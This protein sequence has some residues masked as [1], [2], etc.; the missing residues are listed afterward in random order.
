MFSPRIYLSELSRSLV[1]VIGVLPLASALPGFAQ[2]LVPPAQNFVLRV[3]YLGSASNADVSA[4][5]SF[6][7]ET[8]ISLERQ[9]GGI[10]MGKNP[11][12]AISLD[13]N[14]KLTFV[15]KSAVSAPLSIQYLTALPLHTWTHVAAVLDATT[16]RLYVN[17]ALVA[18]RAFAGPPAGQD[19]RFGL[20]GTADSATVGYNSP[21]LAM[22]QA[23]LWSKALSVTEL[24]TSATRT[25][26]GNE[27]DLVA[28][29][30]LDEGTGLTARDIGPNHFTASLTSFLY[31]AR[32]SIFDAGPY[33]DYQAIASDR[34]CCAKEAA[35]V[36]MG[37][38]KKTI[39]LAYE[40]GYLTPG[41]ARA[42]QLTANGFADVTASVL[43]ISDIKVNTPSDAAVAD[44]NGDGRPDL[45]MATLGVDRFPSPGGQ[46]HIFIQSADGKLVDETA[47]RLPIQ[48]AFTHSMAAA[49]ID[50]DGDNDLFMGNMCCSPS[51]AGS[52]LGPQLYINDGTGRFT[53]KTTGLPSFVANH[54]QSFM[55]S[56]FVDVNNDRIPDLVLGG[57]GGPTPSPNLILLNDGRGNFTSASANSLPPRFGADRW[58][59][60]FI[61]T[62][63]FDGDG[64]VDLIMATHDRGVGPVGL[65]LL[66]NNRNGTFRDASSQIPFN[67]TELS[68]SAA[69][70]VKWIQ[71]LTPLDINGDGKTDFVTHGDAEFVPRLFL[72]QGGANFVDMTE[73]LPPLPQVTKLYP[74]DYDEDGKLDL[75]A[76]SV[77]SPD[78]FLYARGIKTIALPSSAG[79]SYALSAGVRA[80][81]AQGE[82]WSV[83]LTTGSDCPWFVSGLPSW[84][85]ATSASSGLGSASIR[86]QAEQNP[87]SAL[88][89]NFT[90]AGVPFTIF[91]NGTPT[92]TTA[93]CS[94]LIQSNSTI[95]VPVTGTS[96]GLIQVV[97]NQGCAW[98]AAKDASWITLRGG[99]SSSGNGTVSFNVSSNDTGATRSAAIIIAGQ[100]IVVTQAGGVPAGTPVISQGGLVNTASYAPGG[101]PNGSLAQGS[102]FSIY[103]SDLG[104]DQF[105]KAPSYPLPTTLGGVSVAIT[106]A[107]S[108]YDA[109]LVFTSK[110]QINAILPSVV[111][112]GDA[113]VVITFN[114]KTSSPSAIRV[115][116][117]SVGV[118]FQRVG[119]KDLAIAQNIASATEYP[120]NLPS[121]PAKPGQIVIL[122]VTGVGPVSV[123]DNVA[124]GG[125]D[126]T[127]VPVAI[128]VGGITAQRLYAG[129]QPETAAVDNLYF[130]VPTNAPLGCQ[131]PV[132]VT[133]G[134]A[135][136]NTTY[137]AISANGSSCQ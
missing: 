41:P 34:P 52:Q 137:I 122:W 63:D 121:T 135:P 65:Q 1:L 58:S 13:Q 77:L 62:A 60:V 37:P 51:P 43:P 118:F 110:S 80:V 120:L 126:M 98:T 95:S 86:F 18:S 38:K 11:Y 78:P 134:G 24:Q 20:G 105:A 46:S 109:Y 103:G 21:T 75:F 132:A 47:T 44:F 100:V 19:A 116:K 54:A 127:G 102:F 23:R 124:P 40:A 30:P 73:A 108:R 84:V 87:G 69:E 17:G 39:L 29:W 50:G 16:M 104:P 130:T 9:L 57:Q 123:A 53:A 49:D 68:L 35:I 96:D 101:P 97:T 66:L 92:G 42:Y 4:G 106:T 83:D 111:P 112:I 67:G 74:A 125:G 2:T 14:A 129:R 119:G 114:G 36:D 26:L 5:S 91:Q 94:Y 64:Y 28:D 27:P 8:W 15:A 133:V 22:R 113:Q 70:N 72:N 90:L 82:S 10:I 31:W 131:I 93:G 32:T 117:T 61:A 55:A 99:P 45:L 115:V 89:G 107:T 59:V 6:T 128:T 12:Y 25:L 79:C 33:W 85:K 7:M 76:A 136:A 3:P 88:S 56:R 81:V 71:S 48:D